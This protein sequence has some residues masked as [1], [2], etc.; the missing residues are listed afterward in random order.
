[1]V[2]SDEEVDSGCINGSE[3]RYDAMFQFIG[4]LRR[5]SHLGSLNPPIA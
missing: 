4:T 3:K 1:M 5:A 2:Y